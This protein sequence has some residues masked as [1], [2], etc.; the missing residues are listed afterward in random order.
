MIAIT[1]GMVALSALM[2][3]GFVTVYDAV[4]PSLDP[5][6]PAAQVAYRFPRADETFVRVIPGKTQ[7]APAP[8]TARK[9]DKLKVNCKGQEWPYIAQE[10]LVSKDGEPLR[11]V[12]RTVTI[13]R[14][15]GD[16]A[17]ALVRTSVIAFASR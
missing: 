3:A 9:S 13:E 11:K 17:S 14:R 2:S 7:P 5:Q 8:A 15:L 6:S 12:T 4:V 10:C 1:K 16:N